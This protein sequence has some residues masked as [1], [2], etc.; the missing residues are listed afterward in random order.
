MSLEGKGGEGRVIRVGGVVKVRF[1]VL[2][3]M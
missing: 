2:V 1:F 3:N